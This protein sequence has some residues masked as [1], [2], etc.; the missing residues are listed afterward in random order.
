LLGSC[1]INLK[2]FSISL[3]RLIAKQ[4]I[5]GVAKSKGSDLQVPCKHFCPVKQAASELQGTPPNTNCKHW[6]TGKKYS[7]NKSK[8][9]SGV[10][11]PRSRA[12][13]TSWKIGK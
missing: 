12:E 3:G 5:R 10:Q 2:N 8:D 1:Q 7:K 9:T 4:L 6:P 11:T 13:A